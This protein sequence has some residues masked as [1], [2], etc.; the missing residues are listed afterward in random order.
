VATNRNAVRQWVQALGSLTAGSLSEK[1]ATGRVNAMVP[2]L[3]EEFSDAHFT[4]GSLG[5]VA[6]SATFFPAYGEVCKALAAW[7]ADHLP[8]PTA[9]PAPDRPRVRTEAEMEAE[10]RGW[11]QKRVERIQALPSATDRWI[12]AQGMLSTLKM[13]RA[14]PR[15][16]LV[17]QLE[18]ICSAAVEEGAA[19]DQSKVRRAD[20]RFAY[21]AL[22]ESA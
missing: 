13:P 19:A 20:P 8:K 14:Q 7:A 12:E 22:K 1:E 11:W 15:P 16:L 6:K 17:I 5:F 18:R 3:A 9:L 21:L 10:D 2:M 4:P